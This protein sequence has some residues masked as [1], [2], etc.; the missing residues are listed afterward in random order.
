MLDMNVLDFMNLGQVLHLLSLQL[1]N[2]RPEPDIVPTAAMKDGP[3]SSG[4]T[5]T[6]ALPCR[7]RSILLGG[8]ALGE[9]TRSAVCADL[10]CNRV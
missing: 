5:T 1:E 8:L 3:P 6:P 9:V 7:E 4:F 10:A 2:V